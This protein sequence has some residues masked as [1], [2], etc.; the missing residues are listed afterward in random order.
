[1]RYRIGH[2]TLGALGDT[3][4]DTTTTSTSENPTPSWLTALIGG[5]TQI[6]NVISQQQLNTINMQRASQGLP[7][8]PQSVIGPTATVG[9]SADTQNLLV[10]GGLAIGGLVL[11]NMLLR[12]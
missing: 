4:A 5:A 8:L 9:L 11:L 1:M 3:P 6:E 7:P 12:R 10:I 2:R